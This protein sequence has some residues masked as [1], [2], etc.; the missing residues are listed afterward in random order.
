MVQFDF[1]KIIQIANNPDRYNTL[2]VLI[3]DHMM[4]DMTGIELCKRLENKALKKILLTGIADENSV[5]EAFN[6]DIINR[7]VKKN[8]ANSINEL[9]SHIKEMV[10]QYFI[11]L[12]EN[13]KSISLKLTILSDPKFISFFDKLINEHNISEYYLIDK[14]GSYLLIDKNGKKS[15]LAIM[16]DDD[17]EAFSEFFGAERDVQN[18]MSQVKLRKSMPFFGIDVNP[19]NVSITDW[20]KYFF[21]A[22]TLKCED[23]TIYWS[24]CPC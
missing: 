17:L 9:K 8:D 10:L 11:E 21:N 15:V 12:S 3:C 1:S 6:W 20:D 14:N 13:L 4:P 5:I 19:V 2:S 22:S 24:I 7:Y 16:T 18:Y 23:K